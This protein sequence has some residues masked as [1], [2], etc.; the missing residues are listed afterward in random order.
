MK[1]KAKELKKGELI[2]IGGAKAVIEEIEISD[3][4]KQGTKK[5]RLVV[6]TPAGEKITIIRPEDYPFEV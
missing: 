5:V 1:K 4:G 6:K 3:I 2:S